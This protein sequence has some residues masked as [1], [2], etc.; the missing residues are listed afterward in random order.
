MGKKVTILLVVIFGR[1]RVDDE[2]RI[3]LQTAG[4][5]ISE[6]MV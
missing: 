6:G 2:V 3:L 1:D 5:H 4:I